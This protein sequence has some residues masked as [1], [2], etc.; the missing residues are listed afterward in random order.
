MLCYRLGVNTVCY[1]TTCL[2]YSYL[3]IFSMTRIK[4]SA[5]QDGNSARGRQDAFSWDDKVARNCIIVSIRHVSSL[6]WLMKPHHATKFELDWWCYLH[7]WWDVQDVIP[8]ETRHQINWYDS[9]ARRRLNH[10]Q[11]SLM[12]HTVLVEL[13]EKQCRSD[14]RK[15]L[16]SRYQIVWTSTSSPLF[17][18]DPSRFIP[19]RRKLFLV[20]LK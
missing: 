18:Q 14:I 11:H 7:N 13:F 2:L 12:N 17:V 9:Q 16:L 20:H 5:H 19:S 8:K 4:I 1:R 3:L 15:S 10:Y 6:E